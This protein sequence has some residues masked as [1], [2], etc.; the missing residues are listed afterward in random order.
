LRKVIAIN[1]AVDPARSTDNVDRNLF[2]RRFFRRRWLNALLRK[3]A[4]YP[5][6][7]DFNE[8]RADRS[9]RVMTERIIQRY[10]SRLGSFQSADEYFASYA[11]PPATLTQ[12]TVP[13]EIITALDD[14][15]ID[16]AAFKDLPTHPKLTFQPHPTGGHVGYV[17]LFPVQH[18]LPRLVL[19]SLLDDAAVHAH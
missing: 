17:S 12:L 9:I 11:V 13:T 19:H 8:L 6:L 4:H 16:A 14:P 1:P 2:F 18:Y 3:Q 15:I 10:G 5:Q 7:Y